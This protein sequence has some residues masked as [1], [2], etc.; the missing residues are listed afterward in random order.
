MVKIVDLFEKRKKSSKKKL[1]CCYKCAV[2][3]KIKMSEHN[4]HIW[5]QYRNLVGLSSNINKIRFH[6]IL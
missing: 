3:M 4:I 6:T 2:K 1:V 5:F